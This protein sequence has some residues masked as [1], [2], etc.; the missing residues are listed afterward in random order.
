MHHTEVDVPSFGR[1]DPQHPSAPG[2]PDKFNTEDCYCWLHFETN[3][4]LPAG[5]SFLGGH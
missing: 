1:L 2:I 3:L 4:Q 5:G